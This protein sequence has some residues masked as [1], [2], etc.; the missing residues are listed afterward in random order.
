MVVMITGVILGK[1]GRHDT[2]KHLIR[3]R[4][5]VQHSDNNRKDV[6]NASLAMT[7]TD[8]ALLTTII[9]LG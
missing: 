7:E 8:T 6:Q 9:F 2:K 5:F 3:Q 1:R 4:E